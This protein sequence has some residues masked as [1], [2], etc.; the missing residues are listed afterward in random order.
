MITVFARRLVLFIIWT[1]ITT[2]MSILTVL[3]ENDVM[4]M[5]CVGMTLVGMMLSILSLRGIFRIAVNL[6]TYN[7]LTDIQILIIADILNQLSD[8][9]QQK[10]L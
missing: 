4:L 7:M 9:T 5:M 6:D 1:A 8:K 2:A 3:S 10:Q